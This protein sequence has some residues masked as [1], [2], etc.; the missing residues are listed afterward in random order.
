MTDIRTEPT[1]ADVLRH[2]LRHVLRLG[3]HDS[4]SRALREIH[5]LCGSA[6]EWRQVLVRIPLDKLSFQLE[7]GV[8]RA[9]AIAALTG[10]C[11]S[12][13][14]R[15]AGGHQR[16]ESEVFGYLSVLLITLTTM[17]QSD[18]G[19]A[20]EAHDCQGVCHPL[21]QDDSVRRALVELY[22]PARTAEHHVGS[23]WAV[24]RDARFEFH[25]HG[26][27]SFLLRGKP[28]QVTARHTEFA[29]KCVLFPYADIPVIAAK[30]RSYE[31]DHNSLDASGRTVGHMVR[32]WA[33][34]DNWILMDFAEGRTLAEEIDELKREAALP[35]VG[36][37][38]RRQPSPAGNVRLDL[39]RKVGLPLLTA[40][41]ELHRSG[42][43]HEDLSP[44][45][46][47]V[48]RRVPDR[49]GRAYDLTFVD[50]GRNYLYS[51][52]FAGPRT[53]QSA[54]VAPEVRANSEDVAKADL[55]SL[56]HI[57]I[58]LGDV[59]A[60][61][62]DTIPD[63]FYGQAPLI[64]RVVEDLIDVRPDRRL[65]VF[66]VPID[67]ADV[68]HYL[69]Q[70]L[71]QELDVTQAALVDDPDLRPRAIPYDRHTVTETVRTLFPASREPKRRRRIYR[72]RK[73]QGVLADPRRSMHARWLLFFSVVSS[74]SYFTSTT[75]CVLWFL[76][77]IGIDVLGPPVQLVLRP[78]DVPP[79]VIPLV[80]DLR[81]PDY[82]LGLV[83]ENLPA[84]IIGLSFA[85]ASVRYY[86]NIL[87]GVTTLVARSSALPGAPLRIA[88]EIAIRAMAPWA[89]WLILWVNLVDVRDWPLSTA[90]GY[91][92]VVFSNVLCAA[93]ATR[94]LALARAAEL[95]TVPP[96]HQK[97]IGLDAFRQWGPTV[98][99]YSVTV[100]VF[101][102][103][104][105]NGT[106]KDTY[107]YALSVALVNIGLFYVLKTGINALDVRTGLNRCFLA[108]ERLRYEA[109]ANHRPRPLAAPKHP[110]HANPD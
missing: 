95:S 35:V 41:A 27:T 63:R 5:E 93:F 37:F 61:R 6:A 47:I 66:P 89:S 110:V 68:Y 9:T 94:Y 98:T 50:F 19:A 39:I 107:V 32:V 100:W 65:L 33:S 26:S 67:D 82:K 70:V 7:A 25:R 28:G 48:H 84:R 52:A 21:V 17:A 96:E 18:A 74:L 58:A 56:G 31:T 36:R 53:A 62:D 22:S 2:V 24:V 20:Q 4:E 77:D 29:L 46:V 103:L 55:Y 42:K 71:E 10:W 15:R 57:L 87:S 81:V 43:R 13:K 83:W 75:V 8:E 60:N 108:A 106:L 102:Y 92:G 38:R 99:L 90:I 104:I 44:T 16:H 86:Q 34:T 40:L 30:T 51:G 80:D 76:R 88:A 1:G 14:T 12:F 45:N 73:Q 64:A 54:Y 109:E 49:D 79:G 101:A 78:W 105:M 23:E 59:G 72:M 91:S 11:R 97:I 69:R 85:L 3:R